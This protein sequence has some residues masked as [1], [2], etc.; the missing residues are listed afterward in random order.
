MD[1]N[2]QKNSLLNLIIL[3]APAALGL[4]VAQYAGAQ[5]GLIGS[6]ILGIG[7]LVAAINYFHIRLVA[8]EYWERVEF[9][10]LVRNRKESA[11]FSSELE[12]FPARHALA[13]FQRFV[14]PVFTIGILL[15]QISV[16][17][18]FWKHFALAET[19]LEGNRR[20][21]EA[22]ALYG[23]FAL[24]MFLVGKYSV[25]VARLENQPMLRPG[26]SYVMLGA[27][28]SLIIAIAEAA[29]WIGF[30]D[31]D[32][33]IGKGLCIIMG[34]L[35]AETLISLILDIYRPRKE[36]E[37]QKSDSQ[38]VYWL[39]ESRLIGM[40]SYPI[41]IFKT[42]AHALD[43]QFGFSVSETWFYRFLERAFAWLVLLQLGA[44]AL[45]TTFVIVDPHEQASLERF[46]K[47]IKVLESGIH[48]KLPWP[49][50]QVYRT[51]ADQV[52]Q[53][54]IGY[55]EEPE[56]DGVQQNVLLWTKKHYVD[57][58][59]FMV[60]SREMDQESS[61]LGS[62][63]GE[64]AV[65]VNLLTASIPVQYRVKDLENWYYTYSN[66]EQLLQQIATREVVR[67]LVNVDMNSVMAE[68]R[69]EAATA[70]LE[71]IQKR[72]DALELGV[73]LVFVGLQDV[74]PPVEVAAAYEQVIGAFQDKEAR[75]LQAK[76]YEAETVPKAYGE[77]ARI[78]DEAE[79]YKSRVTA[80]AKAE[81]EQF[82]NQLIAFN[83]SPNVYLWRKY[84]ET[85]SAGMKDSRKF[86]IA[87]DNTSDIVEFNLE[88][89]MRPD[90][91]DIPIPEE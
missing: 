36:R 2:L 73:E 18:F 48:F 47:E 68:G 9:D 69:R 89:K 10:E 66:P 6:A 52:R 80:Q 56:E 55:V 16:V 25:G 11:L 3:L 38:D 85:L 19:P 62:E 23:I 28:L 35:S 31:A 46:G 24:A 45:S 15:L 29:K 21:L 90:L 61:G 5:S 49:V 86:V 8:R 4:V 91:L 75:I 64:Q 59:R 12:N 22:M 51:P 7:V 63:T 72:A 60:A 50:D 27:F 76:G 40:F 30:V 44:L 41:G 65:P 53:F 87:A 32:L 33:L 43:Y 78:V 57:E 70:L 17:Y 77:A 14:I 13:Q 79:A 26:A 67:F 84:L 71:N 37:N 1:R 74:H 39:Y 20:S 81:G 58:V 83:A 34:L 42:L 54:N 88:D 82:K